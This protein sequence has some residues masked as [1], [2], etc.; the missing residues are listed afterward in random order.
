MARTARLELADMRA[1]EKEG[2]RQNPIS[3]VRGGAVVGGKSG[4]RKRT[5]KKLLEKIGAEEVAQHK[6][7]H[8]A[9][10]GGARG[11]EA[12]HQGYALAKHFKK[13][14]GGKFSHE[15]IEGMMGGQE[16]SS[17]DEEGGM[18]G[19][20]T[21]GAYEGGMVG[22]PMGSR[23]KSVGGKKK[24]AP[25]SASDGRRKRAEVV[26]KVMAEKGLKMIEASKYVKEHGLY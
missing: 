20:A 8:E 3:E 13:L 12:H 22:A 1:L 2:E 24:R 10:E 9:L 16:E 4:G 5:S 18:S 23:I 19:G 11:T 7:E 6:L 21:T 15:F 25:A 14:H 17:S 26:R